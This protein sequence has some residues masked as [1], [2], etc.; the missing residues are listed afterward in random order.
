MGGVTETNMAEFIAAIEE[1][2]ME[3]LEAYKVAQEMDDDEDEDIG[4]AEQDD[5]DDEEGEGQEEA[6]ETEGEMPESKG[7]EDEENFEVHRKRSRRAGQWLR[8]ILRREM[9]IK[10]VRMM[11]EVKEKLTEQK[12]TVVNNRRHPARHATPHTYPCTFLIHRRYVCC[13]SK[14]KVTRLLTTYICKK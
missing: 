5:M 2:T 8:R 1:Q 7:K 13:T 11:R 3:V 4:D 9:M 10:L 14:C 6:K 12:I